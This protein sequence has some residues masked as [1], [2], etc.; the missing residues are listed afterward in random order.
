LDIDT[1]IETERYITHGTL[2]FHSHRQTFIRITLVILCSRQKRGISWG[3]QA[4][5]ISEPSYEV[6]AN[7]PKLMLLIFTVIFGA[8]GIYEIVKSFSLGQTGFIVAVVGIFVLGSAVLIQVIY[9]LNSIRI[10]RTCCEFMNSVSRIIGAWSVSYFL[11]FSCSSYA[12]T[13]GNYLELTFG[14]SDSAGLSFYR[15][16]SSPQTLNSAPYF[17]RV[18]AMVKVDKQILRLTRIPL[19]AVELHRWKE[20]G[21]KWKVP[22]VQDEALV[23]LITSNSFQYFLKNYRRL[24]GIALIDA[25]AVEAY[26]NHPSIKGQF[27][28]GKTLRVRIVSVKPKAIS[29]RTE[30]LQTYHEHL[31]EVGKRILNHTYKGIEQGRLAERVDLQK[32]P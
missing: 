4:V 24:G 9:R 15:F 26:I 29:K 14:R 32:E 27:M 2:R 23:E 18:R 16:L 11:P 22:V 13:D 1:Q 25:A 7:G 8:L 21:E 20:N 10:R 6:R 28:Y 5:S 17:T 30:I 19:D 3:N 12:E 31:I